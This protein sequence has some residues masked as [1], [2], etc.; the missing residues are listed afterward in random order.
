MTDRAPLSR[1]LICLGPDPLDISRLV[2]QFPGIRIDQVPP[3]DV[4]AH[5]GDADAM[6]VG[7]V[8]ARETLDRAPRLRW[9]QTAGA[10]VEGVVGDG[11]ADRGI[12]LTN[13]SGVMATNMAEHIIGLMLAFA[14]GLPAILDAQRRH[15][16]KS[17]VGMETV[18]EILGQT[19]VLVGLGDIALATAERLKPFGVSVIGVRRTVT[20]TDLPPFVDRVVSIAE[21]DDV[22]GEADH[23][24]SSL[25]HTAG[26]IGVFDAARFARFRDGAYFYNVGRGTSVVQPDLVAALHSGNLG[27]AGLDVTTPEPLLADDPLW[28]APNVI[29]TGHTAGATPRFRQRALELFGENIRRYQSGEPLINVVDIARGY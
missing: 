11:F 24:I 1:I 12:L 9:I 2:R 17:G 27:G 3:D 25:P 8:S 21:I 26:T 18:F 22:L 10:G 29:I 5:V 13:G 4:A 6:L 23:V 15:V 20:G 7:W 16:W 28:D 14:R 19:V